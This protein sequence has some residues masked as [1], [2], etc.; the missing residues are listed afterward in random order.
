MPVPALQSTGLIV[1]APGLSCPMACESFLDQGPNLCPLHWQVDSSPPSHQG[2][3]TEIINVL[4]SVATRKTL[5]VNHEIHFKSLILA[6]SFVLGVLVVSY[7]FLHRIILQRGCSEK[8]EKIFPR[9]FLRYEVQVHEEI[10]LE[11]LT[12]LK[13]LFV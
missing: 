13:E 8:M 2:S 6:N 11:A 4:F 10:D 5:N 9:F 12:Q 7:F 3:P 1:G